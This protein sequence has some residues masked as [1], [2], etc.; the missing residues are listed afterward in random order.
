MTD[1][2]GLNIKAFKEMG[3]GELRRR[4]AEN[5]GARSCFCRACASNLTR[6]TAELRRRGLTLRA[7]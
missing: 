7:A 2:N 5:Y 6:A 1:H 3:E 4:I